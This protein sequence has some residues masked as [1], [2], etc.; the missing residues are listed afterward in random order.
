MNMHMHAIEWK[1]IYKSEWGDRKDT[2]WGLVGAY[3]PNEDD[4]TCQF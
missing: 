1:D 4:K 2:F 3:W